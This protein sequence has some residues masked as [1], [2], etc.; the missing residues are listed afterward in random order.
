MSKLDENFFNLPVEEQQ[1]IIIMANPEEQ[2]QLKNLFK[3]R[4]EKEVCRF[5][6][7]IN[8]ILD[9]EELENDDLM[10]IYLRCKGIQ[11]H[12]RELR[13]ISMLDELESVFGSNSKQENKPIEKA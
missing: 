9:K 2:K 12:K 13:M 4:A 5:K 1:K 10:Q 8:K 11:M 3:E 7:E 6:D